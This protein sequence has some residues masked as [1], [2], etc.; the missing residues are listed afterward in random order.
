MDL[1]QA[2]FMLKYGDAVLE[3]YDMPTDKQ[4]EQMLFLLL[5][6]DEDK[7]LEISTD[8]DTPPPDNFDNMDTEGE[9]ARPSGHSGNG[10]SS[11]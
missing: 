5:P 2:K 6:Q 1:S 4:I 10:N 9:E 8:E 3:K 11:A 7:E